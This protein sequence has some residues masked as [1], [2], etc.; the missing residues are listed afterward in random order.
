MLSSFFNRDPKYSFAYD[1]SAE[2]K[3][4]ENGL[5]IGSTFKKSDTSIIG[6]YF[7]VCASKG[8]GLKSQIQKL[9]T[10]KHPSILA[11][12]DSLETGDK[13]Y[14]I[15]EECKPLKAYIDEANLS[16][17]QYEMFVSWGM[18]Q[19][20]NLLKFLHI[21][22]KKSHGTLRRNI[23]VTPAGDWKLSGFEKF[24]NFTSPVKDLNDFGILLW[25]CFNGFNDG[26]EKA[27]AP[28][29]MPQKLHAPY[30][31]MAS[32]GASKT[33][34]DQILQECKDQN[35]FLRNQFVKTLLFLEEY[36]LK[37]Q[38]EKVAFFSGLKE[39]LDLFPANVAKYKI[40]PKLIQCYEFGDAGVHILTPLFKI[41]AFLEEDEY[42]RIVVPCIVKLFAS[43]DRSIRVRLL[44]K[45]EEFA[46]H[47]SANVIN[48]KIYAPIT[49]GFNDPSPAIREMTVKSVVHFADKLNYNNINVDLMRHL[50]RLQGSDDNPGTR[51]N[52]TICLGKI[53]FYIDPSQ[54]QKILLSAFTR[55]LKDPFPPNRIAG[56][57]AMSATQ[58]F[59][60][61]IEV[62]NRIIPALGPATFDPE[63]QVRDQSFKALKGFIDKLEK[64][65]ENA[66][67]LQEMEAGVKAGG[68]NGILSSEKVPAWASWALKSLSGKIYKGTPPPVVTKETEANEVPNKAPEIKQQNIYSKP[69]K[70][71]SVLPKEPVNVVKSNISDGWDNVDDDSLD[72]FAKTNSSSDIGSGWNDDGDSFL[73]MQPI[74]LPKPE[75]KSN[76][77]EAKYEEEKFVDA[78][79]TFKN[80]S[81]KS[82][83]LGGTK[84]TNKLNADDMDS[85]FGITSKSIVESARGSRCAS[86]AGDKEVSMSSTEVKPKVVKPVI[87]AK[88][89]VTATAE[90]GDSWDSFNWG[91]TMK[92]DQNKDDLKAKRRAE[93]A[94]RNEKKK[95][96][97]AAKRTA[98]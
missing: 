44:E 75:V 3:Y 17:I 48:E 42:Q 45:V 59:Y 92:A 49:A 63:K 38:G 19:I 23:Y 57:L 76:K 61:L 11:Y 8:S 14:L 20:L 96:E 67:L 39:T 5:Q 89:K 6:T 31:S 7:S 37:E 74:D 35:G 51:T 91:E 82:L 54:R 64:V 56:I 1:V 73:D 78:A 93:L 90:G 55:A 53:G 98:K 2:S 41:G 10:L 46:T 28:A 84:V 60:S 66:E 43:P 85:F 21:D 13:I 79:D 26:L 16:S 32:S 29:D 30:K 52:A 80:S 94:A 83:K 71:E 87:R 65:S 68:K 50:A 97:L 34:A 47:M 9:K 40:L 12:V 58:Q 33:S 70:T 24:D 27:K 86:V 95:A 15:T 36:Q 4:Q 88:P 81:A 22:A 77:C 62:A 25:E 69:H 72:D 18:Y